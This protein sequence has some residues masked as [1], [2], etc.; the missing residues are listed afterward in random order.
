MGM[1]CPWLP[2]VQPNASKP[3]AW[4][5]A[6]AFVYGGNALI[7]VDGSPVDG[8]TALGRSRLWT[9]EARSRLWTAEARSRLW[10]GQDND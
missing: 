2:L 8:W 5:A 7:A 4:R 10:T 6:A 9:A 3:E 1:G